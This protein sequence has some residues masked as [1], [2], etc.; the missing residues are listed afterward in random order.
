ML[1]YLIK[2]KINI[3]TLSVTL[4]LQTI[5]ELIEKSTF[6][7]IPSPVQVIF[8]HK[9]YLTRFF[10]KNIYKLHIKRIINFFHLY[11]LHCFNLR[12]CV[13]LRLS[14]APT[15]QDILIQNFLFHELIS[16]YKLLKIHNIFLMISEIQLCL[17]SYATKIASSICIFVTFNDLKIWIP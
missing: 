4:F 11:A 13:M 15:G 5:N 16:K 12:F 14:P 7:P 10:K 17:F 6:K 2:I 3:R 8:N 9:K 1:N